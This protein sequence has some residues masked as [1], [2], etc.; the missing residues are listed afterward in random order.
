V[1]FQVSP[2]RICGGH[3]GSLKGLSVVPRVCELASSHFVIVWDWPC[4]TLCTDSIVKLTLKVRKCAN[5]LLMFVFF[6]I[7][8]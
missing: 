8:Y 2:C 3:N 6:L 7:L 1:E 4:V 5:S